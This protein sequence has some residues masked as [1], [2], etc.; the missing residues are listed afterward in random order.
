M[1]EYMHPPFTYKCTNNANTLQV[2]IIYCHLKSHRIPYLEEII[3]ILVAKVA[4]SD[5]GA[6]VPAVEGCSGELETANVQHEARHGRHR[7]PA[8]VEVGK[9]GVSGGRGRG[10]VGG[11]VHVHGVMTSR[12]KKR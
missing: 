9:P 12:I 4:R 2:F 11:D 3:A 6:H 5:L 1:G 10:G 8:Q 7:V